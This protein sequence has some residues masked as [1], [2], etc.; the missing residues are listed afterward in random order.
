MQNDQ[1]QFSRES[2]NFKIQGMVLMK[3][4][5]QKLL[6]GTVKHGKRKFFQFSSLQS[7]QHKTGLIH[8]RIKESRKFRV[9]H[10]NKHSIE[11]N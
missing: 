8:K 7:I 4:T 2:D 6:V 10:G 1:V 3:A 5:K 9:Y 11:S